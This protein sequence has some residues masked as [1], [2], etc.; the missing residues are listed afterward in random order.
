MF[1]WSGRRNT[2]RFSISRCLPSLNSLA[3]RESQIASVTI[4]SH[5]AAAHQHIH[6][7]FSV[8]QTLSTSAF[9]PIRVSSR[10]VTAETVFPTQALAACSSALSWYCMS[11]SNTTT[12]LNEISSSL[13]DRRL[14]ISLN[15]LYS[16][17]VYINIWK[18][19]MYGVCIPIM[20]CYSHCKNCAID[21]GEL[22]C[23]TKTYFVCLYQWL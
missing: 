15:V 8:W 6:R 11:H 12:A 4:A 2:N 10:S 13:F 21:F 19:D 1:I 9:A 22:E 23:R 7:R 3:M 5:R 20:G 14:W 17:A 16:F 18:M